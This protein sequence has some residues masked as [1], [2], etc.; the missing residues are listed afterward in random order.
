MMFSRTVLILVPAACLLAQNPVPKAS[1]QPQI[2]V[3]PPSL[4]APATPP[5]P[6]DRV[7]ISV[8]DFKLTAAQFD[9]LVSGLPAQTRAAARGPAKKQ[10]A[11][12]LVQVFLLAEEGKRRKLDETPEY[13]T[14]AEFQAE[15][16]L[17]ARTF[18]MISETVKVDDA[19]LQ[20]YYEDHKKEYEQVHAR[21]I[22]IRASGSPQPVEPG[23][24]ELS[25]Q[26]ALAKAQE[27][28]KQLA[29]GADFSK[30]AA[31]ESDDTGS[32]NK[33]GDLSFFHRGQ[34]VPQFEEAAF[35]L[36]VGEISQPVK[37]QYG[38]HIIQVEGKKGFEE[39][40]A[41]I[42][43]KVRNEVARKTLA[44]MQKGAN[45]TLDPEFFGTPAIPAPPAV[46]A[47][48][49]APAK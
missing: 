38:Y 6:A 18:G 43:Q 37:T 46:P 9:Q 21:H 48:P 12:N 20:K 8:G 36:N 27:I 25:D 1:A 2:T 3:A 4:S 47:A 32:K 16:L 49:T 23:K 29:D 31:T 14:Q 22:L 40:K 5:V 33:G 7:V 34:M 15:N 10:F 30:L 17:A 41:D 45:V 44:D 13:K 26:E 35:A 24:K 19:E 42:E 11:E 39:A 28:R